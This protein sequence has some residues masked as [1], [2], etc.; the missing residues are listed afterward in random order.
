MISWRLGACDAANAHAFVRDVQERPNR[1]QL[2]TDGA[3]VYLDA[4]MDYFA[5]IDYAM[6]Q[7][8][9]GPGE[10]GPEHS[11]SAA[12]CHGTKKKV[13]GNPDPED[14]ST[15]FVERQNLS[16]TMQNRRYSR[17]TDA[18]SKKPMLPYSVAI[19]FF[20]HEFHASIRHSA[21]PQRWHPG[22]RIIS[23]RLRK[24]WTLCPKLPTPPVVG[25]KIHTGPLPGIA[26]AA[27]PTQ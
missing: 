7:R 26:P 5:E 10:G 15:S 1:V 12:K 9:Y 4:V 11:Y 19:T 18:F 20:R 22:L 2:T 27:F 23:G 21:L 16:V 8:L 24:W 14:T 6:L 25:L 3:R 13:M 17:L